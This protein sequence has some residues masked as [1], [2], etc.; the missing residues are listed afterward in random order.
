M[1]GD[2]LEDVVCVFV[3][4]DMPDSVVA[5]IDATLALDGMQSSEWDDYTATWTYHP[6][7]GLFIVVEEAQ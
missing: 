4:V 1:Q 5:R 7:N 3:S 6:D 2:E